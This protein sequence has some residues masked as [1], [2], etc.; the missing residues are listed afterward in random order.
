MRSEIDAYGVLRVDAAAD[1]ATIRDSY[2]RL[3]RL[4]HPDGVAP[5][6]GRMTELNQAYDQV[7]TPE[8]RARYD[9]G[10]RRWVAVGPGAA[11]RPP[12]S[13]SERGPLARRRAAALNEPTLDFGQYEGWSIAEI[14]EHDP[15]YLRWLS[16][17]SAGVRFRGAIARY[18]PNEPELGWRSALVR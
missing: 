4:Y 6:A 2:R 16:R 8:R 7:K 17:H 10:R 13:P 18:L 3:A 1:D 9:F 11:T 15:N 14:A 5:N 12:T